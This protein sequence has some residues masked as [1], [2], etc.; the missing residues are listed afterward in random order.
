MKEFTYTV[1]MIADN[2]QIK[3][4]VAADTFVDVVE[5]QRSVCVA[6][7][8]AVSGAEVSSWQRVDGRRGVW[9]NEPINVRRR[10]LI[11]AHRR[12]D[13]ITSVAIDR[14]GD[15]AGAIGGRHRMRED[16]PTT[17]SATLMAARAD[18]WG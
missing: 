2:G 4:A 9:V 8:R 10:V 17:D 6:L 13:D 7:T 1:F 11:V 12:G 18:M 15:R 5:T 3:S 16:I 14:L